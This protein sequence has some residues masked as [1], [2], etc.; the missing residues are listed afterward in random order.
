LA[1]NIDTKDSIEVEILL[2]V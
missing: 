1:K 2:C